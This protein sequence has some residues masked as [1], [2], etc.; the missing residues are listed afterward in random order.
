RISGLAPDAAVV[1]TTVRALKVHSGRYLVKP[2]K[3]LSEDLKKEDVRAI[4]EGIGNLRRHLEN[5]RKHGVPAV[6]ALNRFPTDSEAEIEAVLSL[7]RESGAHQAVVSDVHARG[8]QGGEELAHAVLN[9]SEEKANF[10]YL[11]PDEIS[12]VEKIETIAREIYGADGVDFEPA[13]RRACVRYEKMGMGRLPVCMAK[14]QYSFSDDP[15]KVGAPT[16]FRVQVRELHVSAG[17]GFL[18]AICGDMMTMP[19]LG[20]RPALLGI[21]LDAQ[22]E[23]Q[24]LF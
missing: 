5:V 12:I 17:A 16:G 19:G 14:T 7:A 4:E 9:A 6:V 24:G 23:I 18:Y 3:P 22:G 15:R 2:G 13:A 21:D 8:G 1:V 20:T 10:H 11:Y